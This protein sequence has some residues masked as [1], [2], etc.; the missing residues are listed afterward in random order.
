MNIGRSGVLLAF[1]AVFGAVP[2]VVA[3]SEAVSAA[4]GDRYVI[5]A[6]AGGVNFI[7]GSVRIA[8]KD[9]PS[10]L[11]VKGDS[12]E[13]GDRVTT[14]TNGRAEILLNPG[15]YIRLGENSAFAFRTTSLDDLQLVV[16]HGSAI[17]EVFA[18][19]EFR[20]SVEAGGNSFTLVQTGI[21]RID[22]LNGRAS[23]AVWKG[24]AEVGG[25]QEMVKAGREAVV[26]AGRVAVSKFDRGDKDEFETWSKARAK[27]L[28]KATASLKNKDLRDPLMSA[29]RA[30]RWDLYSSFGLW[31][32][33][34][35][36]SVYCFLPF[37]RGWSSPYGYW[38]WND[39]WGYRLPWIIRV[40]SPSGPGTGTGSTP[41]NTSTGPITR[42][43]VTPPFERMQGPSRS[44][45]T[46]IDSGFPSDSGTTR[47]IPPPPVIVI[48]PSPNSPKKP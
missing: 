48:E 34:P 45:R 6:K 42:R 20:V 15:S 46:V 41:G 2:A 39:I 43:D 18:D 11:L 47:S 30:N 36:R 33:D 21:Y 28:A 17:F 24:R 44:G 8:R 10:G 7:S 27:L 32:Y 5:S 1:A 31:V 14:G 16:E 25:G 38:Y 40:P 13:I 4:L 12:V 22:S 26:V 29:F 35:F 37:G 19:N 3:Q 23:V 9:G